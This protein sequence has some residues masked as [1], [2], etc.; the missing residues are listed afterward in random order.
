MW[1]PL[2]FMTYPSQTEGKHVLMCLD[3]S[4]TKEKTLLPTEW[5]L[6][7]HEG[8]GGGSSS[9]AFVLV[10]REL[11]LATPLETMTLPLPPR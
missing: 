11:C 6:G 5:N 10:V 4:P 9:G 7:V 8:V 3:I 2:T 1:Y